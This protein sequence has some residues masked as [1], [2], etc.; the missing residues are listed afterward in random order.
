MSSDFGLS[1]HFE[2]Q[3]AVLGRV[4]EPQMSREWGKDSLAHVLRLRSCSEMG[5]RSRLP[6][7]LQ[8]YASLSLGIWRS[9]CSLFAVE[10]RWYGGMHEIWCLGDGDDGQFLLA[11]WI[12][13][14][15]HVLFAKGFGEE[16][17][18]ILR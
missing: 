10:I 17:S 5:G 15:L 13:P 11:R 7:C 14:F 1:C 16:F 6:V 9:F 12:S 8:S 4:E 18:E 2:T 3:N